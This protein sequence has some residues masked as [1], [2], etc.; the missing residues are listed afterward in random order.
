MQMADIARLAGVSTSTVSRALSGSSLIPQATRSRIAELAK[1]MGYTVNVGAANL[2]K[3]DVQTVALV[4]LSD[5]MQHISDPF[6]LSMIGHVADAVE[7]RGMNLLLTR[8]FDD[9]IERVPDLVLGGE[10][11]G[12]IVIGQ[13]QWHDYLNDLARRGIAMAVWGAVLPDARYPVV[14]SDNAK[15]GHQ[16]TRHLIAQGCRSIAFVG[17]IGFPEGNLRH[18]G[19]RQALREAGLEVNPLLMHPFLF[20]EADTREAVGRWIDQGHAFDGV[21]CGSDVAAINVMSALSSRGL[22][23]P[24]QVKLVGY[25][26]I[27]LARHM[28]P[29]LSSVSQPTDLAGQALVELLFE[30]IAGQPARQVILPTPL[31]VRESSGG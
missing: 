8:L 15:G 3:R 6:L 21:F 4:H 13:L 23:V 26:D 11:A 7:A 2:R 22:K 18:S 25:D 28:H 1:G 12:L 17:D 20:G 24:Q 10:V 30:S 5:N 9:R 27:A 29:A 19:Y 16:A 14:G 31:M